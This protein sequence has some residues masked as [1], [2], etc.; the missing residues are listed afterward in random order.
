MSSINPPDSGTIIF[1]Y[2][3]RKILSVLGVITLLF[4][5]FKIYE[6]PRF[7]PEHKFEFIGYW[8][9][10]CLMFIAIPVWML[11]KIRKSIRMYRNEDEWKK[12]Q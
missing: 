4:I 5:P 1:Y 3:Y 11:L 10:T 8:F 7:S 12:M 2:R 6:A 9:D